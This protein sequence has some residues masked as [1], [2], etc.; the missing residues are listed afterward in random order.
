MWR[1]V[2]ILLGL[3]SCG[4]GWEPS[5]LSAIQDEV[6]RSL[7]RTEPDYSA[8]SLEFANPS[9]LPKLCEQSLCRSVGGCYFEDG[10]AYVS[11]YRANCGNVLA[12][13]LA[14]YVLHYEGAHG[15]DKDHSLVH[16]WWTD[17]LRGYYCDG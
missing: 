16:V 15:G 9:E 12:H 4:A 10:R 8:L 6:W 1:A 2:P 3:A 14:H 13:E 5:N 17:A 7:Q 11:T